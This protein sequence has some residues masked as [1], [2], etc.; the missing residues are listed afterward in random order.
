[1]KNDT[2]KICKKDACITASGDN[3]DLLVSVVSAVIIVFAAVTVAKL[4]S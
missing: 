4:L 2:V 3:A 1:M